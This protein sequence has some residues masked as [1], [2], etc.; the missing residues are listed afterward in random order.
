MYAKWLRRGRSKQA[1]EFSDA[2]H[3]RDVDRGDDSTFFNLVDA[4]IHAYHCR[5]FL[6]GIC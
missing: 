6:C 1:K 3:E 5:W 2:M 4:V